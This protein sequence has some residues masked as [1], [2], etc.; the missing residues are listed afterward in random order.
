MTRSNPSRGSLSKHRYQI[1]DVKLF[2]VWCS[3]CGWSTALNT[4]IG[5][6]LF[7]YKL[8]QY[9]HKYQKLRIF[10]EMIRIAR[11]NVHTMANATY[12]AS[13]CNNIFHRL[14]RSIQDN[15]NNKSERWELIRLKNDHSIRE[16]KS[17]IRDSENSE[18]K[19]E[20]LYWTA[21]Q[22][23]RKRRRAEELHLLPCSGTIRYS[24]SLAIPFSIR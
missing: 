21:S 23:W 15:T 24:P 8:Y 18:I 14:H 13:V 11:E 10:T 2:K 16:Y 7:D 4:L 1:T 22:V 20:S 12:Q 3:L 6:L 19:I 5:R 9:F 17:R